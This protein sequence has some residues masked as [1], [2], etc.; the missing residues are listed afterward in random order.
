[1]NYFLILIILCLGGAGYYEY[2]TMQ[3]QIADMD[4][5]IKDLETKNKALEDKDAELTKTA[6]VAPTPPPAPIAPASPATPVS[7]APRPAS[8]GPGNDLGEIRTTDGKVYEN[9]KLLHVKAKGIVV[10]QAQGITEIPY[11]VMQVD[12]QQRFGYDPMTGT[13]LTPDQVQA[14]EAARQAAGN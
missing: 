5:T 2:T 3:Q 9:C 1:M 13:D 8:S 10:N 6:T 11:S 14:D 7:P 12:L 4:S